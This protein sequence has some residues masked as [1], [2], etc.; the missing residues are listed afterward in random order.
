MVG[1]GGHHSA[2]L[3]EK[4]STRLELYLSVPLNTVCLGDMIGFELVFIALLFGGK[5]NPKF[6]IQ[7]L[8]SFLPNNS[9]TM[10]VWTVAK[11]LIYT[12][13]RKAESEKLCIGEYVP[14]NAD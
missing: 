6:C 2:F 3:R 13:H 14:D 7:G 8:I 1:A 10:S 12:S 11:K 4:G 9:T 5:G